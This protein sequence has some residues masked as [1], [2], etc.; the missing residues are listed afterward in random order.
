MIKMESNKINSRKEQV[1]VLLIGHGS[2]L[3]ENNKTMT[4]LADMYKEYTDFKVAVAYMELCKPNIPTALDD[5]V[6]NT[7]IDTIIAVPVFLSHGMHTTRDIPKILRIANNDDH[8][9]VHD[10]DN[11]KHSH[12]HEHDHHHEFEKV[13]F[14]GKIIYTEPLGADPLL[15]EIIKNRVDTALK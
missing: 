6:K 5:L 13:N 4:K 11:H 8:N 15:V 7:K 1:G 12:G 2:R 3:P 9:E 14:D 10:H